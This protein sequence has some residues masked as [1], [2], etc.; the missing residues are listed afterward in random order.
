MTA[1]AYQDTEKFSLYF[2]ILADKKILNIEC[3]VLSDAL[4]NGEEGTIIHFVSNLP[5]FKLIADSIKVETLD[6]KEPKT[7]D[8]AEKTSEVKNPEKTKA[9]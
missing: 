6:A 5:I 9:D 4:S 7:D 2:L 3:F 1:C 8:N